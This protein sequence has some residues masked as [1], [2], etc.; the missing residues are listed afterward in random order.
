MTAKADEPEQPEASHAEKWLTEHSQ[1]FNGPP[2]QTQT[3]ADPT[4]F[5]ISI[6]S[7]MPW[8]V[9]SNV[10]RKLEET[11][12][13][14][15]R[16]I[17]CSV[18]LSFFHTPSK[19]FYGSTFIGHQ[20]TF[21]LKNINEIKSLSLSNLNELV[22]FQ[23]RVN[24]PNSVL[25]CELVA[26]LLDPFG[27]G[28][29][30]RFGCGFAIIGPF[31][32]TENDDGSSQR[33]PIKSGSICIYD[34]SPRELLSMKGQGISIFQQLRK[35]ETKSRL[36]FKVWLCSSIGDVI[37]S[38][39]ILQENEIVGAHTM[40]AGLALTTIDCFDDRGSS[41]LHCIGG[42]TT[43]NMLDWNLSPA[44]SL[45]LAPLAAMTMTNI[46]LSIPN[47]A[48]FEQACCQWVSNTQSRSQDGLLGKF[49]R[50]C[51][52]PMKGSR[53]SI[54]VTSR[55]LKIGTHN[56]RAF[57]KWHVIDLEED[58]E[59][60]DVLK[61][62]EIEIQGL[63]HEYFAIVYVLEYT[64]AEETTIKSPTKSVG[65]FNITMGSTVLSPFNE[66]SQGIDSPISLNLVNDTSCS[67][68]SSNMIFSPPNAPKYTL[69]FDIRSKQKRKSNDTKKQTVTQ[70]SHSMSQESVSL[71][72]SSTS[73]FVKRRVSHN[74][75]AKDEFSVGSLPDTS[76]L[77]FD[78][79]LIE[80]NCA[81]D[82]AVAQEKKAPASSNRT[83]C[84]P[85][86]YSVLTEIDDQNNKTEVCI[87]MV[88]FTQSESGTGREIPSSLKFQLKPLFEH[89]DFIT[90]SFTLEQCMFTEQSK[91]TFEYEYTTA[92]AAKH[93]ATY[94]L[95]RSLFIEVFDDGQFHLGTIVL[96]LHLLVRQGKPTRSMDNISVDIIT[97][98]N[99]G[100][101]GSVFVKEG[102]A[103]PGEIVGSILLSI[104]LKGKHSQRYT[105]TTQE[106]YVPEKRHAL[107]LLDTNSELRSL[108]E[109]VKGVTNKIVET[110]S[111]R[112]LVKSET[113]TVDGTSQKQIQLAAIKDYQ[114]R[115]HKAEDKVNSLLSLAKDITPQGP[116]HDDRLLTN[117]AHLI[118]ERIKGDAIE[119]HIANQTKS[120]VVSARPLIG[121]SLLIEI[122]VTNPFPIGECF[123][124]RSSSTGLGL[125]TLL[126]SVAEWDNRRRGYG[127]VV[128][129]GKEALVKF[130]CIQGDQ[131]TMQANQT[132]VLPL[133][134]D[135]RATSRESINI[136][137][138]SLTT[139]NVIDC[140]QIDVT[141]LLQVDR[142][143]LVPCHSNGDIKRHFTFHPQE[144]K[145]LSMK[146][147]DESSL[148]AKCEWS[149]SK[150]TS[151]GT[152]YDLVLQGKCSQKSDETV[153]V[154]IS[155]DNFTSILESWKIV[156]ETRCPLYDTVCLGARICKEI[157]VKGCNNDRLVKCHSMILPND[158]E[159]GGSSSECQFERTSV[160]LMSN[161]VNR[162][163]VTFQFQ[164]AGSWTVL[165]NII[166]EESEELIH[167]YIL[168]VQ[169]YLPVLSKVR[170]KHH[171]QEVI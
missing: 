5:A 132:L 152:A 25:V 40:I 126:S 1:L 142:R 8:N 102:E 84:Q 23:T 141:P 38:A 20:H 82:G 30:K 32:D 78:E 57:M 66:E 48:G 11:P 104:E 144:K 15:E 67:W 109:R 45:K 139:Q 28:I 140:G 134:L 120:R 13:L 71:D 119:A 127:A 74:D 153:Y 42:V 89:D 50:S 121:L 85:N 58:L 44:K 107:N 124:L 155:D 100:L 18:S 26:S 52:P 88:S 69:T 39:S 73:C 9:S 93:L 49:L 92:S 158:L 4:M 83:S 94:M 148:R 108:A 115:Y 87:T 137:L 171:R 157:V 116:Y 101:N 80:E 21:S 65:E 70:Q 7:I 90:T 36:S 123:V 128:L 98:Q 106:C 143:F 63:N 22:Y 14:G 163:Y 95:R 27:D 56:G 61:F 166:D 76:A 165:L 117:A 145:V 72:E 162:L 6:D 81:S 114:Q 168:A 154:V 59:T 156:V 91:I 46:V 129:S 64:L 160:Q 43:G 35:Q 79:S 54:I 97:P 47:R 34:G 146:L 111:E 19:K 169:C 167:S 149:Q 55:K 136:S 112:N 77:T 51:S 164:A 161:Q 3:S 138:V 10:K 86:D 37:R 133:L 41:A 170:N 131:V 31:I 16:R 135:Q 62:S 113:N 24:D 105:E 110:S 12:C 60:V 130:E 75:E 147:V 2:Q 99:V 118:R 33:D 53:S 159:S 68:I 151:K 96:P 103:S 122:E 17:T 29:E 150:C 125:V